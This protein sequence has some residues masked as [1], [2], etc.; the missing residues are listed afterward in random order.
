[1]SISA[2]LVVW[3]VWAVGSGI[4]QL[5]TAASRRSSGGQ[6]PQIVSGAISVVAGVGFLAQSQAATS[7]SGVGGYAILGGIFF[8]ISALRLTALLRRGDGGRRPATSV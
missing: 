7:I 5:V 4:T 6:V 3:G 8:L 2:A 1:M